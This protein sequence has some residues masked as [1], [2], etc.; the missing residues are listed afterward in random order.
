MK[1][2]LETP[3][4]I[5][6][7]LL[8]ACQ[9]IVREKCQHAKKDLMLVNDLVDNVKDYTVKMEN[10]SISW[11]RQTLSLVCFLES[12]MFEASYKLV[13]NLYKQL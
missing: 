1:L 5:A 7:Q 6:E 4:G 9:K 2:K 8:I 13:S 12:I 11:K 10:T 3:I